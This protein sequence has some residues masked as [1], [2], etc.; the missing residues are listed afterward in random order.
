MSLV[1]YFFDTM[2]SNAKITA[3][4]AVSVENA[5][6]RKACPKPLT[7]RGGKHDE[8]QGGADSD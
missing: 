6:I 7:H 1:P 2:T 4:T 8:V 5:R 3:L